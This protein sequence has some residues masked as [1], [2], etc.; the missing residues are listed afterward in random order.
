MI[1]RNVFLF[2]EIQKRKINHFPFPTSKTTFPL[3]GWVVRNYWNKEKMKKLLEL[4]FLP[5]FSFFFSR[6]DLLRGVIPWSSSLI[7]HNGFAPK[8][9]SARLSHPSPRNP[10][11][12]HS[13]NRN[14]THQR[15][16]V[17][18]R[19]VFRSL[20]EFAVCMLSSISHFEFSKEQNK[21]LLSLVS[22]MYFSWIRI[23]AKLCFS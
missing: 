4:I 13:A 5:L 19:C 14:S 10:D 18:S 2:L 23:N 21:M 11:S 20:T 8:Q 12:D 15:D 9:V 17:I 1:K 6:C 22:R 16:E 7:R 3:I